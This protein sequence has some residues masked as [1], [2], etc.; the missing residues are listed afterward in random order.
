[1]VEIIAATFWAF[2]VLGFLGNLE[3]SISFVF[4]FGVLMNRFSR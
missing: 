2:D 3:V 1:M 4:T